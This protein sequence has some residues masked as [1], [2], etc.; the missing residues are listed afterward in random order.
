MDS[1]TDAVTPVK[2]PRLS[3]SR[4]KEFLQCPKLYHYK[5]IEGRTT[6]P[7]VATARGTLAH[8]VF[9]R[10]FD[11]PHE[12]RRTPEA[13]LAF[14]E[15]CWQIMV[16]PFVER[17]SVEAGSMA[18]FARDADDGWVG[19]LELDSY[20][21]K[22]K[23]ESAAAYRLLAPE[24]S[25]EERQIL[26]EATAMVTNYFRV[27][28]PWNFDPEDR[29]L[30][31]FVE[32][33]DVPLIGY[34]D[35]LDRYIT[36]DDEERWV[37]SDYKT[38]KVPNERF[39][40]ENFFA[41]KLYALMLAEQV[42]IVA[43]SIRLIFVGAEPGDAIKPMLVDDAM[44]NSARREIRSIW[45]QITESVATGSWETKKQRL[46]DWCDFKTECPAWN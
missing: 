42:D 36:K 13:A 29:E 11:L 17:S 9:E 23:L 35:R 26:A 34:I 6:P 32:V 24:G 8:A 14:L 30:K 38:G 22:R 15:P 21:A 27:E 20:D 12:Q 46:C 44:L 43:H 10:I 19:D 39:M 37:I 33:D 16:D 2:I 7:T 5:A 3:P 41:M 4:A 31:L 40:D 1:T 45:D 28:R 18:A 25:S